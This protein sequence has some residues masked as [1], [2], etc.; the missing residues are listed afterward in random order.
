MYA[1]TPY[2]YGYTAWV[3]LTQLFVLA[4]CRICLSP[5]GLVIVVPFLSHQTI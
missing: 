5:H 3:F 4:L 2:F 1:V